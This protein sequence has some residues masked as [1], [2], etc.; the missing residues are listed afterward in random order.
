MKK[1]E[2]REA[3]VLTNDENKLFGI[4]HRPLISPPYPAILICHGFGGDKLG[5]NHLYLILA[6]L[7]AK[8]GIA[9]L[10]IDFRGCGDSEGNF[11]E[12]TFENLLSDAKASL[13]FLQ[14]DTCIDQNRLGVLGRSL[15]GALA[16]LL[17]SHTNAF[18]TIC[19]WAPL[20]T[21]EDWKEKWKILQKVKD[22]HQKEELMRVNGKKAS[23]TFYEQLFQMCL[24]KE[25]L[26]LNQVPLMHIQGKNDVIIAD[27]HAQG[28]RKNRE[29]IQAESKFIELPNSDHDF[30]HTEE[31]RLAIEETLTWFKRTL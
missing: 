6:Q 1:T 5:R 27:S 4:L 28:Y 21:A 19:L 3:V 10:R 12:V 30:S 24:D 9:T 20:F 2:T 18:K 25:L 17:A 29:N 8:E 16:V 11:N 13:D 7:L 23:F 15:G 31:Q 14:Q 22:P 26:N